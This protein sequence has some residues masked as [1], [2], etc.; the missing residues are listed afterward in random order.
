MNTSLTYIVASVCRRKILTRFCFTQGD[1]GDITSRKELRRKLKCK[2]FK[3]YLENIYPEL[4]IPGDAVAS[5]EV[6]KI[7]T[8]THTHIYHERDRRNILRSQSSHPRRAHKKFLGKQVYFANFPYC[9]RI[10]SYFIYL[11]GNSISFVFLFSVPR[12]KTIIISSS[13]QSE[14]FPIR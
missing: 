6:K 14:F 4:F 7:H 3:W 9:S 1:Y 10:F 11:I 2:S 8:Q 12:R 13:F 5:G